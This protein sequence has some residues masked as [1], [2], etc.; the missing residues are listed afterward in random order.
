MSKITTGKQVNNFFQRTKCTMC[1]SSVWKYNFHLYLSNVHGI[2]M[3]P[4]EAIICDEEKT[5]IIKNKK[6]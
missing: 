5:Y 2:D 3:L 4:Q 1:T 6:L